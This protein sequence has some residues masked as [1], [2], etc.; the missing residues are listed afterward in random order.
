[1]PNSCR[2][3]WTVNDSNYPL[4]L[5]NL[6]IALFVTHSLSTPQPEITTYILNIFATNRPSFIA[7]CNVIA[8]ISDHETVPVETQL[9]VT[10]TPGRYFY[11]TR[12]SPNKSPHVAVLFRIFYLALLLKY[13]GQLINQFVLNVLILCPYL[14][15]TFFQEILN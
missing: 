12:L 5:C 3:K 4:A 14:Q 6:F 7:K 15:H 10:I 13:Y 1:M 2:N 8:G 11:G 9:S